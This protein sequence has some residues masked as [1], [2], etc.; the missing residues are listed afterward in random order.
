M[1]ATLLL[2]KAGVQVIE[3]QIGPEEGLN[4]LLSTDPAESI[5]AIFYVAGKPVKLFSENTDRLRGLTLVDITNEAVL[6]WGKYEAANFSPRIT[7][8]STGK[9]V[10]YL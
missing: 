4:L 10:P 6:A 7:N 1:T 9:C 5:D 3:S 8:G 2:R